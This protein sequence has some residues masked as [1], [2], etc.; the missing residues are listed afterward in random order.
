MRAAYCPECG[1][2]TVLRQMGDDSAVPFCRQCN[3]PWFD[4]FN[5]C[6]L[7]VVR[8]P[9]GEL[10]LIRQS[11]DAQG[12]FVGVA[13]YMKPG[14]TAE[15]AALREISEEIGTAVREIRF[16]FSAWYERRGQLMLC[17]C[18][19]TDAADFVLSQE[20]REAKWF[21][22]KEALCAVRKGSII[23]RV[24]KHVIEMQNER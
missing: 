7:S 2:K 8:N 4:M 19:E 20:V 10:A 22:P 16:L 17:F 18:A 21:A 12:D 9:K 1:A 5:T 14:E 24:V 3:R 15:A 6:V 11:D 13:G 23:E